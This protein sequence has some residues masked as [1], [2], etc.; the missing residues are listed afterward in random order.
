MSLQLTQTVSLDVYHFVNV[1]G[2]LFGMCI[3][4]RIRKKKQEN[5]TNYEHIFSRDI[6]IFLTEEEKLFH[7]NNYRGRQEIF[8]FLLTAW[9]TFCNKRQI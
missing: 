6:K 2:D 5:Q 4:V 9:I 1:L 7:L 3:L 8:F